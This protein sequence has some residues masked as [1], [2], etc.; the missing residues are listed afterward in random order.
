MKRWFLWL[1]LLLAAALP[2]GFL[3]AAG[4]GMSELSSGHMTVLDNQGAAILKTGLVLAAGDRYISENN[5]VYEITAVEGTLA[6]ARYLGDEPP[7]ETTDRT[8]PVQVPAPPS[9]QLVAVYHTHDDES[10]IPSDGQ[11]A[12]AGGGGIFKVGAA[13]AGRLTEL[14][15]QTEVD[16]TR[17]APHDAN[18]YERSRRTVVRLL[19]HQPAALFDIHRDSGPP[20]DDQVTVNGQNAAKMLLVVG[21]QN[22]YRQTSLDYAKSIKAAA[23]AKHPGLIRGILAA[24]GSYNQDLAPRAMLVEIGTQHSRRQAAEYSAALLADLVPLFLTP[25]TAGSSAQDAKTGM[26][27]AVPLPS[28]AAA[29]SYGRD[30]AAMIGALIAGSALYLFLS[31]GGWPEAKRRLNHFRN[32]EFIN[33]LGIRGKRKK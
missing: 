25:A 29:D 1:G 30:I 22:P 7:G 33:F 15:Y 14:G 26:P 5:R 27:P 21:Q 3:T 12:I 18:A 9:G 4:Y 31:T 8:L 24:H 6:K 20:G 13:F 23:D 17:H 11:A 2:A 32:I 19:S 28:G 10:F 16:Q